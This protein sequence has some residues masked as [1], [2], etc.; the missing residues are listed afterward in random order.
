MIFNT[1]SKKGQVGGMGAHVCTPL[2]QPSCKTLFVE[3]Q[4]HTYKNGL[5]GTNVPFRGTNVALEPCWVPKRRAEGWKA[6]A[7]GR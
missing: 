3:Q 4:L 7:T 2:A 5:P 1:D 6:I